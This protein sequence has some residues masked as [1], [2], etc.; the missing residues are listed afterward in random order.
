MNLHIL[1]NILKRN[2]MNNLFFDMQLG[3][4]LC[5]QNFDTKFEKKNLIPNLKRIC[6]IVSEERLEKVF[7]NDGW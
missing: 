5:R 6:E 2:S 4:F 7:D 3:P 1:K